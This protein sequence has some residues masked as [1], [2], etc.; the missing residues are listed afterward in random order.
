[1]SP[2]TSTDLCHCTH[3]KLYVDVG[4]KCPL[5]LQRWVYPKLWKP[6]A[7]TRILY[8]S[9]DQVR[10]RIVPAFVRGRIVCKSFW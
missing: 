5:T 8:V 1:M 2:V 3:L 9:G 10:H 6:G 4:W 7:S